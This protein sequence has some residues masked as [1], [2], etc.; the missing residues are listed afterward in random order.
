[1]RISDYPNA[2][3]EKCG[4]TKE[5]TR[6]HSHPQ[7]LY[8]GSG[9]IVILCRKCHNEA[10]KYILR[11][12]KYYRFENLTKTLYEQFTHNFLYG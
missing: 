9:P 4:T 12:E 6:H 2:K 3:C 8:K 10:E 7:K 11:N 1:M 5:L